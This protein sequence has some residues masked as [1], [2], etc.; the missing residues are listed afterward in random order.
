MGTEIDAEVR[1]LIAR[2][3]VS[4]S[5]L[6]AGLGV[7][8]PYG[9]GLGGRL[10]VFGAVEERGSALRARF[11]HLCITGY[12]NHATRAWP[13]VQSEELVAVLDASADVE[14]VFVLSGEDLRALGS[15]GVTGLQ[16]RWRATPERWW[17]LVVGN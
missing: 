3:L 17:A 11:V 15:E 12:E 4:E 9:E 10:L 2:T 6:A 13:A 1:D 14:S 7:A 5:A 16:P 8:S